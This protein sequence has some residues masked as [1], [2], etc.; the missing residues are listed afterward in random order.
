MEDS[1]PVEVTLTCPPGQV[2]SLGEA[3]FGRNKYGACTF[4]EGDCKDK[5]DAFEGCE[6]RYNC[7]VHFHR[8]LSPNCGY[9][10]FI[11]VSYDCQTGWCG[12]AVCGGPDP[13][14]GAVVRQCLIRSV[15]MGADRL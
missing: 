11:R 5:T 8:P 3:V 14:S 7:T 12:T 15:A 4:T 13:L 10:T 2:V 1:P 6:G 9:A